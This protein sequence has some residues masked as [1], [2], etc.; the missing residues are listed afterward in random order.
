MDLVFPN[1]RTLG[2]GGGMARRPMVGEP[3]VEEGVRLRAPERTS[4]PSSGLLAL[5]LQGFNSSAERFAVKVTLPE[6]SP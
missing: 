6:C 4:S 3:W 2:A 5:V 1:V